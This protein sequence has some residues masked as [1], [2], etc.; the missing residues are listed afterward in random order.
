MR[1][2]ALAAVALVFS[3]DD[4]PPG[5]PT[6]PVDALWKL[7]PE[8]TRGAVVMSPYAVGMIETGSVRLRS[9][10][11]AAGAEMIPI[12]DQI[13]AMLEPLGGK[14]VKLADYGMTATKGAA[15][16]AAQKS[17]V[18]V[19]PVADRDLFLT[20]VSGTKATTPD[21][22]DQIGPLRCKQQAAHYVCAGSEALL[23]TVGK[24][25]IRDRIAKIN[26]RGDLE[27]V[28]AELPL[29]GPDMPRSAIAAVVQIERGSFVTRGVFVNPPQGLAEVV[30]KSA[31]PRVTMGKSAG[32]ALVDLR[33]VLE[34][35]EFKIYGDIT[36][37]QLVNSIDGPATIE[38]PA[39]AMSIDMQ[40]PLKDGKALAQIVEHC[41]EVP[42][43]QQ[44]GAKK[45]GTSCHVEV[46]QLGL[47]FDI[48][49]EGKTLRLGKQ[50]AQPFEG[51]VPMSAVASELANGQWGLVAWGRGTMFAPTTRPETEPQGMNPLVTAPVRMLSM[52][53]EVGFG[54]KKDGD[55][56]RFVGTIRTG[57]ANPDDVIEK[58]TKITAMDVLGNKAGAKAKSIAEAH[59]K[60]PFAADFAAGQHGLVIPS[61]MLEVGFNFLVPAMLYYTRGEKSQ[62]E[63]QQPDGEAPPQFAPGDVTKMRVKGYA[64]DVFAAWQKQ[65]ADK[66]C[67]T[68]MADL[69]SVIGEG[70]LTTD[71]WGSEL[72]MVC[73]GKL[74]EGAKGIA[75]S[76]P[77]PDKKLGT[78]D[79]IKS[80]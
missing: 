39:G 28:M 35:S 75:I 73:G 76:S 7:A 20:K 72:V 74:P 13:T 53:D 59:P 22:L 36:L 5:R 2:P 1:L 61:R 12:A 43:L 44:L 19:L 80:Y 56:L 79:D 47:A 6:A 58:I 11:T 29:Q 3:C 38:V 8:G 48:W 16:F 67:P 41:E 27:L 46:A 64:T 57:F 78:D 50:G 42:L 68:S 70:V 4:G 65:H 71:E 54:V 45:A 9:F 62:A 77:G 60:T 10:I 31:K 32:F 21:G 17:Y 63:T 26:A 23:G 40:V 25:Q 14:D 18:A 24:S 52:L 33:T 66:P 49:V 55:L 30:E 37:A 15:F 51:T 34:P 69:A